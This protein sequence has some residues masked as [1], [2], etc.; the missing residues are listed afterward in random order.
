ME[1]TNDKTLGIPSDISLR[2]LFSSLRPALQYSITPLQIMPSGLRPNPDPLD[3][4]FYSL[5]YSLTVF[6]AQY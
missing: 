1:K 2:R 6:M 3:P 5:K 4:D